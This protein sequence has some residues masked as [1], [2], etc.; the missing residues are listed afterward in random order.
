M[1]PCCALEDKVL[2][3]LVVGVKLICHPHRLGLAAVAVVNAI[4]GSEF[5]LVCLIGKTR[6]HRRLASALIS[7][8]EVPSFDRNQ[9]KV[10]PMLAT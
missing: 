2:R 1:I 5:S 7:M 8:F 4:T 3:W 6:I 10:K 9:N